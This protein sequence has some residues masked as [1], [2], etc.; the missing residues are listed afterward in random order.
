[1]KIVN[2]QQGT[3]AIVMKLKIN[4]KLNGQQVIYLFFSLIYD[5]LK[6]LIKN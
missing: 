3:K 4:Y 2:G 1:M 6:R 5:D